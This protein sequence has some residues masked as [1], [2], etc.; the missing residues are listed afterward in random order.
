MKWLSIFTLFLLCLIHSGCSTIEKYG[1]FTPIDKNNDWS[2]EKNKK[3]QTYYDETTHYYNSC[4]SISSIRIGFTNTVK[5]LTVGPPLI[6]IL[7]IPFIKNNRFY[8]TIS[9]KTH[10]DIDTS[11]ILKYIHINLNDSL[12]VEPYNSTLH[13][14][15]KT[16]LTFFKSTCDKQSTINNVLRISYRCDIKPNKVQKINISFD[17]KLNDRLDSN[18]KDL[19]LKRKNRLR[20]CGFFFVAS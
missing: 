2:I 13:N 20:Y 5:S 1:Y 15:K 4:D 16:D 18:Y 19:I 12:I 3:Y 14:S 8:I 10:N 17:K 6:P 9:I 7:P 11:A